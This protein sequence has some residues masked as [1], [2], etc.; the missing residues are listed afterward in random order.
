MRLRHNPKADIAIE[1]SRFVEQ[2]PLSRKGHWK[3]LFGN[4]NP[5]HI[6]IG[7]GKGHFLTTLAGQNPDI[8]YIGIERVATVLYKAERKQQELDL[9]NLILIAFNAEKIDEIF[10]KDEIERIYLNFSDPWP[11]DRHAMR[12]LTSPKYLDMYAKFLKKDGFIAFKT[13]NRPLFDYSLETAPA[14]GWKVKDVTYD[15]HNSE[16]ALG[17]IMT[18][19]EMK[20]FAEGIPIN[21]MVIFR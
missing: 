16:Y 4:D 2:D 7:M 13:D 11:K 15:L 19:Y 17:N 6:E 3:E 20:F 14:S 8:N 5:I 1:N 21:R 12:R 18:E 9:K 10:E